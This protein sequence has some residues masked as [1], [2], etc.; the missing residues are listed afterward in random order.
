LLLHNKAVIGYHNQ[1]SE[2]MIRSICDLSDDHP[3][4]VQTGDALFTDY[5]QILKFHGRVA[6]VR[7]YEDNLLLRQILSTPGHGRVIVVDGAGSLRRALI[8]D[9]LGS[10]MIENGWAGAIVNGAARDVEVL[11][12]MPLAVRALNTCPTKPLQTGSG[13]SE[14]VVA[15]AGVIFRPG[16]WLYADENGFIVSAEPLS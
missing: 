9:R 1:P 6:T 2:T 12:T 5:G 4:S 3:N 11:R 13:E 15:F 14:I 7:C 16:E 10:L 8:G